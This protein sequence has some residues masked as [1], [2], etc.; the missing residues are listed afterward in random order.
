LILSTLLL[1]FLELLF[2]SRP[3]FVFTLIEEAGEVL[4]IVI[5]VLFGV[6]REMSLGIHHDQLSLFHALNEQ[7]L[8]IEDAASFTVIVVLLAIIK[9]PQ[10]AC[11]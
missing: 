6:P 3:C 4:F 9:G 5:I 7:L 2:E 11:Y 8:L 10:S 1:S